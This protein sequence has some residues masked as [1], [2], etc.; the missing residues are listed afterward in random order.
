MRFEYIWIDETWIL[1][2]GAKAQVGQYLGLYIFT[3]EEPTYCCEVRPS[4]WME[5]VGFETQHAAS[6]EL[7]GEL[8]SYLY[9]SSHYRH[10]ADVNCRNPRLL[11]CF[12]D[13]HE[14]R[15]YAN[16]NPPCY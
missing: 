9:D 3:P 10:C 12:E 8:N 2:Q 6:D 11:G 4:Y 16:S 15:E 5:A 13:L 14:A 1:T 7:W